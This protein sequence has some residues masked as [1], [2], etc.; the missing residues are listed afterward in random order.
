MLSD[1]VEISTALVLGKGI[2]IG[3][4]IYTHFHKNKVIKLELVMRYQVLFSIATDNLD[5]IYIYL[6]NFAAIYNA[7][8]LVPLLCVNVENVLRYL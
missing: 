4:K 8:F 1:N 2:F 5:S 6:I 7:D 3:Y